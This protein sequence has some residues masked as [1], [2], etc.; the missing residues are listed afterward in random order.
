[1]E[2][3]FNKNPEIQD[4]Q[5]QLN[6]LQLRYD[7]F[8]Q[9]KASQLCLEQLQPLYP[10]R[11]LWLTHSGTAA[12]E[13]AAHLLLNTS[14]KEVIVPSF[15]F[16][17]TALAFQNKGFQLKFAEADEDSLSAS[18]SD[19]YSLM[20]ENTAAV[21]WMHYA[22][23][24][25]PGFEQLL[26]FCQQKGVLVIEDA[27]LGFGRTHQQKS[28]G[29]FGTAAIFS[30]DITKPFSAIQGGLLVLAHPQWREL[31]DQYYHIGTNRAAFEKG[32][33]ANYQWVS[34]GSKCQMNELN[35][36]FLLQDLAHS[37]LKMAKLQALS[38]YYLAK[39]SALENKD[40]F[41]IPTVFKDP[42]NHH[43]FGLLFASEAL[44]LHVQ[45]TM[46]HAQIEVF[47][48]Y[49]ALHNTPF[50]KQNGLYRELPFAQKLSTQFLRLP[51]HEDLT[52][53]QI[54]QLLWTFKEALNSFFKQ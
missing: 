8:R 38:R 2:I 46:R 45:K 49:Q 29:N 3:K 31:A 5:A 42:D 43:V 40:H 37:D 26:E 13:M 1:M 18:I 34:E 14:K 36:A 15:S 30:F 27:A 33:V 50:A 35:A 22:G 17:S 41:K 7:D 48:H 9:K 28:L 52:F 51:L 32:L 24:V 20:N 16:V 47:S 25:A 10:Q 11:N 53:E 4:F 21:V 6:A 23:S 19:V 54:D 39:L 12:L 44:T